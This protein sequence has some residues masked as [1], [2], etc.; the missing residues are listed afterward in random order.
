MTSTLKKWPTWASQALQGVTYWIGHRRCLYP[1]YPLSEGALVAEICNL[2][3]ANLSDNFSLKCEVLYSSI[4]RRD[5]EPTE[6]TVRARADLVIVEKE[7]GSDDAPITRF[8]IEVKRAAAPRAQIDADLRRL[9]VARC[10]LPDIRAFLFIISEARRPTR[11]VNEEGMS[12]R[13]KQ[14]IP[15]SRGYFRVRRTWKAAHAFTKRERAQYACLIEVYPPQE[16]SQHSTDSTAKK[17]N[18]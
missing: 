6:L 2:I 5:E 18:R 11:F 3:N 15:Q 17:R 12:V 4:V 1:H 9:L 10:T 13:G 14:P 16:Q 8:L 7:K